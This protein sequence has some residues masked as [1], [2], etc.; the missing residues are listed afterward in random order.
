MKHEFKTISERTGLIYQAKPASLYGYYKGYMLA[1]RHLVSQQRF[2]M[3]IWVTDNASDPTQLILDHM[4]QYQARHPYLAAYTYQNRVLYVQVSFIKDSQQMVDNLMDFL[5]DAVSFFAAHQLI[6]ACEDCGNP[7][8]LTLF[9]AEGNYFF[10]CQGCLDAMSER[11]KEQNAI[12]RKPHNPVAGV[13]GALL[14]SLA[15]VALWVII[16]QLGYIA[17]LAGL[18]IT[19]C[20]F[21]GY[22][23]FGH[24]MS[25]LGAGLCIAV[26]VL[27]VLFAQYLCLGIE[28]YSVF[29]D[30]YE[31]TIFDALRSVPF[32]LQ[33]P[34]I[35]S[36]CVKDLVMGYGLAAL[37]SFS[38]VRE[39]LK[40]QDDGFAYDRLVEPD[41][42]NS[43]AL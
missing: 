7:N 39:A 32:F 24:R 4:A 33:E 19:V 36:A 5:D 21:K 30:G 6:S 17:A 25:K 2:E 28:I 10:K 11:V 18:V 16:Y 43:P 41:G 38:F 1:A 20:A 23:F 37:G 27:M 14:F 31:V 40:I 26:S 3:K 34:E 15:G 29:R 13:V 35:V 22:E 42:M 8:G 12:N 9:R